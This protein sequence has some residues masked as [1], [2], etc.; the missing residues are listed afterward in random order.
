MEITDLEFEL[1]SNFV[2]EKIGV[3]LKEHNR[4]LIIFRLSKRLEA[5][6]LCNFHDYYEY[7][8]KDKQGKELHY[9]VDKITT[10]Y[11]Y[12]LRERSQFD[13]FE[14][15]VL[16]QLY[17]SID[18]G[19]L[20]VWSTATSSGEEAYTLAMILDEFFIDCED[21]N[22]QLLATDISRVAVSKAKSGIYSDVQIANI[23]QTWKLKYFEKYIDKKF[24]VKEFLREEIIFRCF[25]LLDSYYPFSRKFHVIFCKNVLIYFDKESK[26]KVISKLVEFLEPGGYLFLGLS[27]S[28][29]YAEYGLSYV[30]PSV[31]F[32]G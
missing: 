19:D 21:W 1:F 6:D 32:K 12:F 10:H 4:A 9:F 18:D 23:P 22:K 3:K 28:I 15:I 27:E 2:R 5:L 7:L 29:N 11:T 13:F 30:R 16:P 8:K 20:R 14:E 25:N 26:K 24:R 17:N 31:Y